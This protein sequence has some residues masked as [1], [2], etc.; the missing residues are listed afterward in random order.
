MGVGLRVKRPFLLRDPNR[1][2]D[3]MTAVSETLQY[4]A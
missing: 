2:W 3:V 1:S 4:E